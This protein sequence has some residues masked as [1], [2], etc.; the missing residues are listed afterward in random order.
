MKTYQIIQG[1]M[2]VAVSGWKLARRVSQRG[3]LGV[4]SST[5]ID[6]VMVRILQDGDEFGHV[7]RALSAFPD[8]NV[9]NEVVARYFIYGGKAAGAAYTVKPMIGETPGKRALQLI[10][11]ANFVEV[12]LAKEDHEG[13][14]GINFLQKIQ[15]PILAGLY[16]A[17]L[18]GVACVQPG[19][20]ARRAIVDGFEQFD[21]V[22]VGEITG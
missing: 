17:M 16:G 6:L 12:Y 1:G 3:Q 9:A 7:R 11:A 22:I 13:S 15:A 21:I 2:G 18:A 4:V 14:I 5:A 8:Q 10:V 19:D 20:V